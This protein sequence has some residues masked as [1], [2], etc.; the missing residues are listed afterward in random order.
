MVRYMI[1]NQADK[2][3][4]KKQCLALEKNIPDLQK[5]KCLQ[6]VDGSEIQVYNIGENPVYVHNSIYLNEVYIETAV[7]LKKYFKF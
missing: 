5:I 3:I 4:F 7:D 1:C 6:D 2:N